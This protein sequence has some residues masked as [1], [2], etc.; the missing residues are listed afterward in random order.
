[1]IGLSKIE[2][3]IDFLVF[4]CSREDDRR[5]KNFREKHAAIVIQ[6]GWR[7]HNRLHKNAFTNRTKQNSFD[8]VDYCFYHLQ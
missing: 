4:I 5:V 7:R 2:L 1:M 8:K 6:R 3:I